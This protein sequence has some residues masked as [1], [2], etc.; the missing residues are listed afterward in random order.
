VCIYN[1][2]GIRGSEPVLE[3]IR[4]TIAASAGQVQPEK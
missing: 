3:A 2:E 4:Q 1:W